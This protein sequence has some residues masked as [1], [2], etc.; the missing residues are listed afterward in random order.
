MW[1]IVLPLRNK[2]TNKKKEN[3]QTNTKHQFFIL[4][5][6]EIMAITKNMA[7]SPKNLTLAVEVF[8]GG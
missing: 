2:Q 3:K 4:Q 6:K 8:Q 7:D 1:K 5:I